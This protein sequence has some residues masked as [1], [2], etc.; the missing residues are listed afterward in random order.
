MG[1]L[2]YDADILPPSDDRIFKLILISPDGKPALKDLVSALLGRSV[3]DVVVR[4]SEIPPGDTDEKAE[5]LDVN[6][7]VDDGSQVD[8]EMP[9]VGLASRRR[10]AGLKK[11][12]TARTTG[13][14]TSRGKGF[15]ICATCI[16]RNRQKGSGAMT[17]WQELIKSR[18]AI[19][20]SSPKERISSIP[21]L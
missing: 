17:G 6:C 10:P 18:S 3:L 16:P 15:T 19:I 2:P 14:R 7:G 20:R 9:L 1:L 8:I 4:N 11:T 5:R 13:S 12:M 21:F